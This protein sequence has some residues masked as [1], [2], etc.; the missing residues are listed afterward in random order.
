MFQCNFKFH[1]YCVTHFLH[2]FGFNCIIMLTFSFLAQKYCLNRKGM[3]YI[4]HNR[5]L[6]ILYHGFVLVENE[7]FYDNFVNYCQRIV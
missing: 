7:C 1:K 5:T 6:D 2:T 3:L 4:K